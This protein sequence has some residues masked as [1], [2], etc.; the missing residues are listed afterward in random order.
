MCSSPLEF[1]S[2][3]EQG[4]LDE[5]MRLVRPIREAGAVLALFRRGIA[6]DDI[7]FPS[8][9]GSAG[10]GVEVTGTGRPSLPFFFLALFRGLYPAAS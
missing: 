2:E 6:F 4:V 9:A 7:S 8:S 10:V 1:S 5:M 3:S